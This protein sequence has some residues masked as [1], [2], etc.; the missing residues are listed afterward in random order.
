MMSTPARRPGPQD[1]QPRSPNRVSTADNSPLSQNCIIQL[2]Q[3]GVGSDEAK[4]KV[5]EG[6]LRQ[7]KSERQGVFREESVVVGVRFFVGA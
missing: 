3:S 2:A 1:R 4:V 5:G 6:L 7:V